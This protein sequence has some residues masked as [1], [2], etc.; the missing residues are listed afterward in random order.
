MNSEWR[1]MSR[2]DAVSGSSHVG[3]TR[4]C[5]RCSSPLV[6]VSRYAILNT[7]STV[8]RSGLENGSRIRHEPAWACR[9]DACSYR[10]FPSDI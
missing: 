5:P 2:D 4:R 1:P 7:R 8:G 6:F 3:G 9:N 10:E